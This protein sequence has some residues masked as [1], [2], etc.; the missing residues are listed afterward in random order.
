MNN[1]PKVTVL[2]QRPRRGPGRGNALTAAEREEVIRLGALGEAKTRIARR[3]NASRR[4]V[5]RTLHSPHAEEFRLDVKAELAKNRAQ[6]VGDWI[7]ASANAARYGNH[8]PAKEA[9]EVLGDVER[10]H[11]VGTAVQVQVGFVLPGLPQPPR[12]LVDPRRSLAGAAGTAP[13]D[14]DRGVERQKG[15]EGSP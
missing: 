12:S 11:A 9:L 13:T 5:Y 4:A 8:K 3:V 10:P 1:D 7:E 14:V 6:F 2:E 15:A